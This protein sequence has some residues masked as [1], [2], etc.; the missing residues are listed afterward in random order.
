MQEI[1]NR[2]KTIGGASIFLVLILN[3]LSLS[4]WQ[5]NLADLIAALPGK[6]PTNPVTA[7]CF[8]CSVISFYYL[9]GENKNSQFAGKMLAWLFFLTGVVKFSEVILHYSTGI[10]KWLYTEKLVLYQVG[11][12]PVAMAPNTALVF[13]LLGLSF[14][15]YHFRSK[16]KNIIADCFALIAA[17]ASFVSLIGYLYHTD[18]FYNIRPFI[19]MA[20]PTAISFFLM[21]FAVLLKRSGFGLLHVFAQQYEGSKMGRFLLPFVIIIPVATGLLRVYGERRNLY[22]G[23]FGVALY[24]VTNVVL[25]LLVTWRCSLSLNRSGKEL[26]KEMGER[27]HLEELLRQNNRKLEQKVR[28]RTQ[29]I[30]INEQ[31]FYSLIENSADVIVI[32]DAQLKITYVSPAIEKILGIKPRELFTET[33]DDLVHPDY[34]KMAQDLTRSALDIPGMPMTAILKVRHYDGHY[35]WMEGTVTNLLQDKSVSG[36]VSNFHDVTERI[37]AEEQKKLFQEALLQEKINLQRKLIQ[38][39]IDGQEKERKQIGMEL[40]DNINQILGSAQL[41]L[42]FA[43]SEADIKQEMLEKSSKL[44]NKAIKEIR[45]LSSLL[46]SHAV[47][48]DNL[49]KGINN[50]IHTIELTTNLAIRT[51]LPEDILDKLD[52]KVKIAFYRIIQEQLNNIVKH[53]SASNVCID[54]QEDEDFVTLRIGDDGIGFDPD[55]RPAGIGLSNIRSRTELL[56]GE[57]IIQSATKEGCKLIIRIP[58]YQILEVYDVPKK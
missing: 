34:L 53:A 40:H 31:R 41:Y 6:T 55:S 24:T 47:E 13:V 23:S 57:M 56:N 10:D 9:A 38:A 18:E 26:F 14:L 25:L 32:R 11:G 17:L 50:F 49:P 5:F 21:S 19:P 12:R 35:I 43:K 16:E 28:E 48:G 7:L 3:L 52:P 36:I 15:F 39:N 1:V 27:A 4:A 58:C 22:S 42:C 20:L 33:G 46:V 30:L 2:N 54:L 29:Q 44:V 8:I 51:R 45:K 37:K